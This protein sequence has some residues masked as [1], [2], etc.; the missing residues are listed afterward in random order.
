MTKF[1]CYEQKSLWLITI[2][3]RAF[4]RVYLS[5]YNINDVDNIVSSNRSF[6]AQRARLISS[7]RDHSLLNHMI[8]SFD[9][10]KM[11]LHISVAVCFS[12]FSGLALCSDPVPIVIW[13]GMGKTFKTFNGMTLSY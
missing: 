13:H 8:V 1:P 10:I 9:K 12:L 4:I 7:T 3:V 11:K 2:F 5:S 6:L